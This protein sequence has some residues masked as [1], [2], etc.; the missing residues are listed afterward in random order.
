M[1]NMIG[2]MLNEVPGIRVIDFAVDGQDAVG[3]VQAL[4]PDVV[5]MDVEMPHL[6]GIQAV[7]QIMRICPTPVIM[8]SSLTQQGALTTIEALEKGAVD[9]VG[10]PSG[11]VSIDI[12]RV[13]DDLV[14]KILR[15]SK[16]GSARLM[17]LAAPPPATMAAVVMPA[18]RPLPTGRQRVV[19]IGTS[20]GGPK[21]L[22]EVIPRLPKN[23]GVPVLIVQHMPAGFTR[24]LAQRLNDLSQI[25]VRE[26]AAGDVLQ[27][28]VALVAPG[29]YHMTVVVGGR[30][31]LNQDAPVHNVRPAVDVLLESVVKV[32]GRDTV[33]V[34]LTGMGNDGAQ[35]ALAIKRTGGRVIVQDEATSV[36]YG[37]PRS[38]VDAGAADMVVPLSRVA[39]EIVKALS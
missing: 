2:K 14:N 26:A 31:V 27:P 36:V 22:N 11:T 38:V 32:Y 7:E 28:G 6:N 1:R 39:D 20:T 10:K 24:A 13:R 12:H 15:A 9:F 34:V 3:K 25:T 16:V 30:I 19:A 8:L 29:D 33:G 17:A 37:M 4:R 21:A 18:L 5:T 23:L 35:G